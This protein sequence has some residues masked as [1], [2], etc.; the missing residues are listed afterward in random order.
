M[1]ATAAP[2][3]PTGTE[4]TANQT[5][6]Q[7]E[8]VSL[9]L[10]ANTFTVP[11]SETLTYTTSQSSGQALTSWLSF[12][13]S[14]KTFSGTVPTSMENL[15]FKVTATDTG[16]LSISETFGATVPPVPAAKPPTRSGRRDRRSAW[17]CGRTPSL[18]R[19]ARR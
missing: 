18:I 13:A 15:T 1:T 19:R 4:Q 5:W 17:R 3:V 8:K 7:R 11:Q 16:G 9:A 12:N 10:P 6:T 14:T 2:Q